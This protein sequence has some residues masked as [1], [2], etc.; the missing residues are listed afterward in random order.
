MYIQIPIGIVVG[1]VSFIAGAVSMFGLGLLANKAQERRNARILAGVRR[2]IEED[3]CEGS[4]IPN[5][6]P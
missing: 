5:P 1:V 4:E 2:A 6:M 3:E